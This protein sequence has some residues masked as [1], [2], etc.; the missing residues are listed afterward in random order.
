M[1]CIIHNKPAPHTI[2][3]YFPQIESSLPVHDKTCARQAFNQL[4][5]GLTKQEQPAIIH[6]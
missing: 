4:L 5:N 2:D 1:T 6:A 3:W